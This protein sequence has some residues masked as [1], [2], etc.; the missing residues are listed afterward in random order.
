[1]NKTVY[2]V[3]GYAP[4][5]GA[6]MA[7]HVARIL[8]VDFGYDVRVIDIG[9]NA[10]QGQPLE[11][12][13]YDPLFPCVP[14]QGCEEL[15][16]DDDVLL[17]NPSFSMLNLG[18]RLRGRKLM[19]VQDFKTFSVL[20]CF[21]DRYVA[22]SGFVNGFLKQTYGIQTNVIP[23]FVP[24]TELEWQDAC[25]LTPKKA[26]EARPTHS[27]ELNLKAIKGD[28]SQQLLLLGRVR[29][30]LKAKDSDLEEAIDWDAALQRAQSRI[31][32]NQ[33]LERTASARYLLTLSVAEGFG[34]V[35]LEAMGM[36]TVVL[37]F[38]GYGGR[39][40]MV[41][42]KNCAVVPYPDV[43]GLVDGIIHAMRD[44]AFSQRIAA[45]GV[46]TASRYNYEAFRS[47]WVQELGV[48]LSR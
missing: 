32:R 12:F 39:E 1:M 43:S 24:G 14:F 41:S 5:G 17:C 20:D 11:L 36:G 18:L 47:A 46:E 25:H 28:W 38:D 40:Y 9:R 35:P 42:G 2:V 19:Y 29:R 22:V 23:A 10:D 15:V 48:F 37:G 45:S 7:Y 44:P 8:H 26:W 30:E 4:Y 6:Y 13:H 31:P 34:L 27:I 33:L 3:G 21:F 16:R